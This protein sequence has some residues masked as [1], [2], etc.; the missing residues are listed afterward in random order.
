M[1]KIISNNITLQ[2]WV[3]FE[4]ISGFLQ[5]MFHR[6][7]LMFHFRKINKDFPQRSLPLETLLFQEV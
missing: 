5:L 6:F 7:M 3:L 2:P 4:T 1:I